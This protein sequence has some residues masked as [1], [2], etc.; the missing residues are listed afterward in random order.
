MK[1]VLDKTGYYV[2]IS[3]QTD[4]VVAI[5]GSGENQEISDKLERAVKDHEVADVVKLEAVEDREKGK[6]LFMNV[7]SDGDSSLFSYFLEKTE[8]Y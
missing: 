7:T 5:I 4:E 6:V 3:G 2:L 1:I 8:V